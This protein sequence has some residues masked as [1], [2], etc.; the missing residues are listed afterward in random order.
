MVA[1]KCGVG[2]EALHKFVTSIF[3]EGSSVL[4]SRRMLTGRFF[5]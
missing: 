2:N 4:Y 5:P 1:E 3:P